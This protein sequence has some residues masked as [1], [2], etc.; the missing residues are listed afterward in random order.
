MK[1]IPKMSKKSTSYSQRV[2]V[3]TRRDPGG[4]VDMEVSILLVAMILRKTNATVEAAWQFEKHSNVCE[5]HTGLYSVSQ[6]M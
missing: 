4:M 6:Y 1:L 5:L 2:I 3:V